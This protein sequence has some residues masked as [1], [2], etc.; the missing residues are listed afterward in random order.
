MKAFYIIILISAF[1]FFGFAGAQSSPEFLVSWSVNNYVPE[2]Y[3]GKILPVAG[4][5]VIVSFELIFGGKPVNLSQNAVRWYV[6]GNLVRNENDGLGIKSII[7]PAVSGEGGGMTVRAVITDYAEGI[8][9]KSVIIPIAVPEAVID[10]PYP[11]N[12]ISVGQSVFRAYP[13]FFNTDGV[14]GLSVG[15]KVND[16]ASLED[17]GDPWILSVNIAGQAVSG[18]RITINSAL[19]NISN[20][21]ETASQNIILSVK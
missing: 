19:K 13:F 15:W 7:S 2:W 18:S 17:E 12:K 16:S 3:S 8:I 4:T 14:D 21:F 11:D 5:S 9:Q 1:S 20:I 6:N 10:S